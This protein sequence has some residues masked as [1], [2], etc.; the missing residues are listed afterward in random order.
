[1]DPIMRSNHK[2][3][4]EEKQIYEE[5]QKNRRNFIIKFNKGKEVVIRSFKQENPKRKSHDNLFD[6]PKRI[7][8]NVPKYIPTPIEKLPRHPSFPPPLIEFNAPDDKEKERSWLPKVNTS[9]NVKSIDP[10]DQLGSCSSTSSSISSSSSSSSKTKTYTPESIKPKLN[11]ISET[12]TKT[13]DSIKPKL[14]QISENNHNWIILNVGGKMFGTSK[15]TVSK[16]NGGLLAKLV[17][18]ESGVKP[19]LAKNCSTPIYR[20]DRDPKH[21]DQILNYLRN[22]GET[23]ISR[24]I[25]LNYSALEEFLLEAKY[26]ELSGLVT[27][28]QSRPLALDVVNSTLIL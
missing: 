23:P 5:F 15:D 8:P 24:L 26:Y 25:P 10:I 17:H 21:F 12:K 3:G 6:P 11:Q 9:S 18:P 22:V 1:M 2:F 13:P 20:I 19:I 7:K 16:D 4:P 27:I 28:I 14:N